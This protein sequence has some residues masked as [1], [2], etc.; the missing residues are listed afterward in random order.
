MESAGSGYP[1]NPGIAL[2][3][4]LA[5][6]SVEMVGT[7]RSGVVGV[8][9]L[10]AMGSRSAKTGTG[11]GETGTLFGK[12]GTILGEKGTILEESGIILGETGT[13]RGVDGTRF[14]LAAA[15]VRQGLSAPLY[16]MV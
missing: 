6:G 13:L 14:S 15:F 10:S 11:G 1:S 9:F 2:K 3:A 7:D 4:L 5:K 12:T 16:Y 8:I